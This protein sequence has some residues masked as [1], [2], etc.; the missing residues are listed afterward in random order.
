M[1]QLKQ[2]TEIYFFSGVPLDRNYKNVMMFKS[3]TNRDSLS[4]S[5]PF[6]NFS[7]ISF[8]MG[9]QPQRPISFIDEF[10]GKIR[11]LWS[12]GSTSDIYTFNYLKF[13]NNYEPINNETSTNYRWHDWVYC[14][15]DNIKYINNNTY[16]VYFTIDIFTT[17]QFGIAWGTTPQFIERMHVSNDGVGVHNLDEGLATGEYILRPMGNPLMDDTSSLTWDFKS[18]MAIVVCE[19]GIHWGDNDENE[20]IPDVMRFRANVPGD[21]LCKVFDA[22]NA[23]EMAILQAHLT[24]LSNNGQTNAPFSIFMFPTALLAGVRV[25]TED[26]TN[27]YAYFGLIDNGLR[28]MSYSTTLET[29]EESGLRLLPSVY[30]TYNL[31]TTI[32]GYAPKNK[33]LL[34]SPYTNLYIRTSDG[35]CATYDISRFSRTNGNP[36]IA[37]RMFGN[38][39]VNPEIVLYPE[40]YKDYGSSLHHNINEGLVVSQFPTVMWKSNQ[41][42]EWLAQNQ[43]KREVAITS[44][45]IRG[46]VGILGGGAMSLAGGELASVAGGLTALNSATSTATDLANMWAEKKTAQLMPDAMHGVST[47]DI[48]CAT[49]NFGYNVYFQQITREYAAIIDQYFTAFGYKVNTLANIPHLLSDGSKFSNNRPYYTYVKTV[50]CT[51]KP[52]QSQGNGSNRHGMLNKYIDEI[53]KIFDRGTTIWNGSAVV[54]S[55]PILYSAN[56]GNY[57][58]PI[59]DNS[60]VT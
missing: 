20:R 46:A 60:P 8:T 44:S 28:N 32:D 10:S 24:W 6:A 30:K 13:R 53:N 59:I 11:I 55:E 9:T 40:F 29:D 34:T 12:V 51:L 7:R 35:D 56:F 3:K 19:S 1:P 49:N 26:I 43:F 2:A 45:A 5:A 25:E 16:E 27:G 31:P 39:G 15:I 47:K 58:S 41:Y 22:G 21:Y 4:G 54:N 23:Y 48:S 36:L 37:I 18:P 14:F 33:K 17:F 50:G 42:K 57:N 52:L 38:W